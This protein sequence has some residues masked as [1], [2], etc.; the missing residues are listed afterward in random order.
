MRNPNINSGHTELIS[1]IGI[2]TTE[3]LLHFQVRWN[4]YLE[5]VDEIKVNYGI[6]KV[7]KFTHKF[8]D[9]FEK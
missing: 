1:H 7:G 5:I 3:K 2:I 4:G 9:E 6:Y 8:T